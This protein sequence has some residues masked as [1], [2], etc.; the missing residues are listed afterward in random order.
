MY[1]AFTSA[2][3]VMGVYEYQN[4]LLDDNGNCIGNEKD[5][6]DLARN[7]TIGSGIVTG[8]DIPLIGSIVDEQ[9]LQGDTSANIWVSDV[10]SSNTIVKVWAVIVPPGN[11]KEDSTAMFIQWLL[12]T[13]I[14]MIEVLSERAVKARSSSEKDSVT[15]A[16]VAAISGCSG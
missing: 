4:A 2:K 1:G 11:E 3:N 9:I 5:D 15:K 13:P 6:G 16:I 7:Y 8:G 10:T 12:N 14:F